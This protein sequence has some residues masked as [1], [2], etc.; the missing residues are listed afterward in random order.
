MLNTVLGDDGIQKW[1]Q[2]FFKRTDAESIDDE[3]FVEAETTGPALNISVTK[4]TA[5][6]AN[7]FF[8]MGQ[9]DDKENAEEGHKIF[10]VDFTFSLFCPKFPRDGKCKVLSLIFSRTASGTKWKALNDS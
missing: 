4:K 2:R 8:S 10:D 6:V 9:K 5:T 1:L 7:T 3:Y